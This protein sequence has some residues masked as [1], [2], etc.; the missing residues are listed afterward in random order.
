MANFTVV[1]D[2]CILYPFTLR[3]LFVELAMT[4]LF[5]AKWTKQIHT[6]WTE[7]L[8]R[9]NPKCTKEYLEKLKT[10]LN[11]A[12]PD[13]LVTDYDGLVPTLN[14][15]DNND[16]HVLAAAIRCGAQAIVTNNLKDF[17]DGSIKSYDIEAL[18]ADT[19]ICLQ[20]GLSQG[21][22]LS[23]VKKSRSWLNPLPTSEVYLQR[24]MRQGLIKT[25]AILRDSQELI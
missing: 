3:T 12:I 1:Y 2:S 13:S 15:P 14:L 9:N 16:R 18:D 20:F 25:V 23:A 5:Q 4:G 17:P 22:V 11:N 7:S 8:H 6:E 24:L 10:L 21:K 19:F